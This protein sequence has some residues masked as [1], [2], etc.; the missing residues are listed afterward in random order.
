[1]L[2]IKIFLHVINARTFYDTKHISTKELTFL[3]VNLKII[4]KIENFTIHYFKI[5]DVV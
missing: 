4:T 5:A 1:M 3:H 2:C